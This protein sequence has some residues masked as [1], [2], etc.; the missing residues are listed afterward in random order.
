MV[1]LAVGDGGVSRLEVAGEGVDGGTGTRG[2][3]VVSLNP[4]CD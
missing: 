3:G 4:A 1:P 2:L